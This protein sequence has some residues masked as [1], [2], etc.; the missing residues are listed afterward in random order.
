MHRD[1]K[2]TIRDRD[3]RAAPTRPKDGSSGRRV[4][5]ASRSSHRDRQAFPQTASRYRER[6]RESPDRHRPS[7]SAAPPIPFRRR[8]P[9][10]NARG[11]RYARRSRSPPTGWRD[12][13]PHRA[14]RPFFPQRPRPVSAARDHSLRLTRTLRVALLHP[15]MQR[16]NPSIAGRLIE[17]R[18]AFGAEREGFGVAFLPGFERIEA[19][20]QHEQELIAQHL[21]GGAQF[22]L[23]AMALAQKPRLAIGA[24]VTEAWKYQ[25]NH[26][27]P[28]EKRQEVVEVAI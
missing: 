11:R 2:T 7:P 16:G 8:T 28:V 4:N 24:A 18:V 13:A 3:P 21:S 22:T 25:R 26:R 12:E 27:K 10:P 1:R 20:A 15:L 5:R 14:L 17:Y 19:G 6:S 23:V 9:A